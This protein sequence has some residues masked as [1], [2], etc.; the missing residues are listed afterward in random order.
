[1]ALLAVERI[2]VFLSGFDARLRSRQR[3]GR[4]GWAPGAAEAPRA[5]LPSVMSAPPSCELAPCLLSPADGAQVDTLLPTFT[6]DAGTEDDALSRLHIC[7][8][9]DVPCGGYPSFLIVGGPGI[10]ALRPQENLPARQV[11]WAIGVRK[12]GLVRSRIKQS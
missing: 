7:T 8:T 9:D 1:M 12:V 6:W 5:Y 2:S 11:W 3:T 4:G 10:H